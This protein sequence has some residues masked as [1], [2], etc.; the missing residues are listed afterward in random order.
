MLWLVSADKNALLNGQ[1]AWTTK[2]RVS[3]NDLNMNKDPLSK[4]FSIGE[5][6][7]VQ[8]M[9]RL[10]ITERTHAG[11]ETVIECTASRANISKLR[12]LKE[13]TKGE[14]NGNI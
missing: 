9:T 6:K 12:K 11:L 13:G 5:T 4:E 2:E 3:V 7:R 8:T 1:A 14:E 10:R